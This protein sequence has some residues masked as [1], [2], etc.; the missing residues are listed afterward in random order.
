[1][2]HFLATKLL[3]SLKE[4]FDPNLEDMLVELRDKSLPDLWEA[5]WGPF[6]A[7]QSHALLAAQLRNRTGH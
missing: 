6:T 5:S 3:R 7:T 1:M 2:D 4:R